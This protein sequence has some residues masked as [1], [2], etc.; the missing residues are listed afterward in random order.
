MILF[1]ALQAST[2]LTHLTTLT[3]GGVVF[4]PLTHRENPQDELTGSFIQ[5]K[6]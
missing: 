5:H 1:T 6:R 2:E 4:L 3:Q